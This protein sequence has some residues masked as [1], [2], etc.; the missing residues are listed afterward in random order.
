[1]DFILADVFH[2]HD[3]WP[4]YRNISR[5]A[6]R[7]LVLEIDGLQRDFWRLRE[8]SRA[9]LNGRKPGYGYSEEE[10]EM[11]KKLRHKLIEM[12][13]DGPLSHRLEDAG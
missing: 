12:R 4:R 10:N 1:M 13:K 5:H 3:V 11:L 7:A 6:L 8:K 9:K 2:S